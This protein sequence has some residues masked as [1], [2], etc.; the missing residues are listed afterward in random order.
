[1]EAQSPKELTLLK[2]SFHI[3]AVWEQKQGGPKKSANQKIQGGN[4]G[5]ANK[6]QQ[7]KIEIKH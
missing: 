1:V 7:V 2:G 3:C 5:Q 4:L 6:K